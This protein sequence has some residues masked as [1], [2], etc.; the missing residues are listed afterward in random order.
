MGCL[1]NAVY[2]RAYWITYRVVIGEL[3]E[4]CLL[5]SLF[6]VYW[7]AYGALESNDSAHQTVCLAHA[8]KFIQNNVIVGNP[9]RISENTIPTQSD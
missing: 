1:L 2:W 9:L 6:S 7:V 3:I 8:W 5:A 4:H